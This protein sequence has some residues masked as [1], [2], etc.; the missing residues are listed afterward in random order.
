M[1]KKESNKPVSDEKDAQETQK[2]KRL[3]LKLLNADREVQDAVA[4]TIKADPAKTPDSS[5][6]LKEKDEEIARLKNERDQLRRERDALKNQLLDAN[7][8][9]EDNVTRLENEKKRLQSEIAELGHKYGDLDELERIFGAYNSLPQ[10]LKNSM[11]GFIRGDSLLSFT[12]SGMRDSRL[13]MF[14]EFCRTEVQRSSGLQYAPEIA[15]IFTFFFTKINSIT[16]SPLYELYA[17]RE[18]S[19][20]NDETMTV[21]NSSAARDG[22]V[23]KTVLPGYSGKISQKTVKKAIVI[24][25]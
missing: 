17:P 18:G 11:A 25:K 3:F 16:E 24:L 20:F 2:L 6:L 19:R 5:K 23:E 13:D 7:A 21:S 9:L 14:W 10:T 4:L 12:V 15:A 8:K 22:A 1:D